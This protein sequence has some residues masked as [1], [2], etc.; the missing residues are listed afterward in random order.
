[1][2]N[3]QAGEALNLALQWARLSSPIDTGN[4]RWNSI[5]LEVLGDGVWRI[6]IDEEQAPYAKYTNESWDNFRPPLQG[7]QNPNEGW[8]E[9]TCKRIMETLRQIFGGELEAIQ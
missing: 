7:K 8:W 3:E 1:M 5:K 4:L 9:D 6:Y 2:T